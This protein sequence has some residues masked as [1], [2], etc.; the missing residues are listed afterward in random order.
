MSQLKVTAM[1]VPDV[2]RSVFEVSSRDW[3][4]DLA[5]KPPEMYETL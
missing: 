3:F 1:L 2:N 4:R 5:R